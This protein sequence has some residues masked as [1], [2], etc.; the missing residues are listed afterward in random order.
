MVQR[1]LVHRSILW[2][3]APLLLMSL[4]AGYGCSSAPSTVFDSGEPEELQLAEQVAMKYIDLELAP[5][6]LSR[7]NFTT[8]GVFI[9]E[10]AMAHT[11][12][13]QV[14]GGVRVFGGEA[15][16]HL[17]PDGS[18]FG[19]TD[20]HVQGITGDVNT[21]PQIDMKS[22]RELAL[23]QY[24]CS[25]CLKEEPKVDLWILHRP[26]SSR[27][28]PRLAYRVQIERF[29][30][31]RTEMPI[32]FIDAET[33]EALWRYDNL[34]TFTMPSNTRY[35]GQQNVDVYDN[36]GFGKFADDVP[37]KF[38]V[39]DY[40]EGTSASYLGRFSTMSTVWNGPS[41]DALWGTAKTLDYFKN[42]HMRNGIDGTGGPTGKLAIDGKTNV[43][44]VGVRY[45]A[46]YNDAFWTGT[47]IACGLGNGTARGP[48][49]A[50]DIVGH[51]LTHGIIDKTA[52][53]IYSGESG[54]LNESIADVFGAMV[55]RYAKGEGTRTWQMYEDAHTPNSAGDALRYMND[56]HL[57]ANN[58]VTPDDDPDH[59]TERYTG[60][61]DNGGVHTNS[62]IGNKA[63][64]LLAKG[65]AHH[66][67]GSMAD[68]GQANGIGADKAAAIWY[69]ALTTYL[70]STAGYGAMR[71]ATIDAATATHGAASAEVAAV[72]QAWKL[73]GVDQAPANVCSHDVCTIGGALVNGCDT[74]VAKVCAA[75]ASCCTTTWDDACINTAKTTC[76]K[77]CGVCSSA[78]F[79]AA[80]TTKGETTVGAAPNFQSN[81]NFSGA[82]WA[83]LTPSANQQFLMNK[84]GEI[85][86][87][88][89]EWT[90]YIAP[91]G[92]VC[93]SGGNPGVAI[94]YSSSLANQWHHYAFSYAGGVVTLFEDGVQKAQ[95]SGIP[96][97]AP[98]NT[99]LKIG[100]FGQGY[101]FGLNGQLDHAAIWNKALTATDVQ[102]LVQRTKSPAGIGS[103]L[104][105]W[106]FNNEGSTTVSDN[107]NNGRTLTM[108]NASFTASCANNGSCPANMQDVNGNG[109]LCQP[110]ASC[111][112]LKAA[113]PMTAD[114]MHPI[115]P[116]GQAGNLPFN[117]YCDMTQDGGGWTALFNHGTTFD[118]A[119]TGTVD[120]DCFNTGSCTSRAFSTVPITA[121]LMF[122]VSDTAFTAAGHNA[123]T[124]VKGVDTTSIGKN[125]RYLFNTAGTWY[126]EKTDRSNVTNIFKAGYTC[127]SWSEYTALVLCG[128][129]P[130]YRIQFNDTTFGG[131]AGPFAIGDAFTGNATGWPARPNSSQNWWPD[132]FRV[133]VR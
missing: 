115:D 18:L 15:I 120:V 97:V 19:L 26:E 46:F 40:G 8:S 107:S 23:S 29:D 43:M 2:V 24:D 62:G 116:D 102:A 128:T 4:G 61:A 85:G 83:K 41:A 25:T 52:K 5:L 125:L 78:V 77:T 117:A 28:E 95:Q 10:L 108:Q 9:D 71:T 45:G 103:L 35:S 32:I 96:V 31:E 89:T 11:R 56:P 126:V 55:D 91:N 70:T 58:G 30:H 59:Y 60:T 87:V 27:N 47:G 65:G 73:V 69:K 131:S 130:T 12:V 33:G 57:A 118:K 133:W 51:E 110:Y 67:G 76:G 80:G 39:Y 82:L 63:F 53:L 66:K 112:A 121:D 6:G 113:K 50:I 105:D 79:N 74:C 36:G 49:T 94:C 88:I 22:A 64:Y 54:A 93:F 132:Y 90:F 21:V 129:D 16:V 72:K 100:N 14:Q 98:K 7:Q 75:K 124:L 84:G 42:V 44:V 48:S 86:G 81:S 119:S 109:S 13:Q 123:R 37:R 127:A 3:V 122:D 34:Q 20:D 17:N 114:G 111:K 104:A 92:N 68:I 38:G 1:S 101:A 106:L 99:S